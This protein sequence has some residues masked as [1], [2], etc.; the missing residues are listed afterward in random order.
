MPTIWRSLLFVPANNPK[1]IAKA[2]TCNAD[3][4]IL[5]LEDSVPDS[6]L[7]NA[8]LG[9]RKAVASV[10]RCGAEVLVRVNNSNQLCIDDIQAAVIE[11]VAAIMLPKARDAIH[12][13]SVSEA[14]AKRERAEG[15]AAGGVRLV[16]MIETATAYF[17]SFEIGTAD[18]R[19]IAMS[20][21]GED[22]AV[23]VG[24]IPDSDTL[25]MPKQQVVIA[26][27]AAR[28]IPLG[29]MGTVANFQDLNGIR[30][31]AE[32]SRRFGVEGAPCVHPSNIEILN[33]AFSP[34][35]SEID[36][37]ERVVNAYSEAI[38]KGRAA[39]TLDGNMIDVP[40][41]RRAEIL[42]ARWEAIKAR[43]SRG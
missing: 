39:T 1:F 42:L 4:I 33:S 10:S 18:P 40:V 43:Q 36:Y 20:L 21:G 7:D 12:V 3:G 29:L 11:G 19:N 25:A 24:M 13:Q 32:M 34:S 17:R 14:I 16:P 35:S 26:A 8:R 37:A 5:D 38:S 22:F 28:L 30:R 2:H 15:I 9:L 6:E 41:V 27:R 23:D 31:I